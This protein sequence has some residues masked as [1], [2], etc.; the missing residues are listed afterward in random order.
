MA[1]PF[2]SYPFDAAGVDSFTRPIFIMAFRAPTTNDIQNP[3]TRW[4]NNAVNPPVISE[5]TG[6]GRW[7]D[8]T[9]GG[10]GEFTTITVDG[11]I[12][13]NGGADLN[14]GGTTINIGA[15]DSDDAI[16]IGIGGERVITLGSNQGA[17]AINILTGT[18]GFNFV[19]IEVPI[20]MDGGLAT[21]FIGTA[22]LVAGTVTIANTLLTANDR[23]FISRIAVN[24]STTLG[25]L[26][27]AITPATSFTITSATLGT[28][29]TPQAGDLSTV[30]YIIFRQ[31]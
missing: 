21:S 24:S 11:L 18:G 28:P 12:T 29:G 19:D 5:T 16:N 4:Q 25:E 31:T 20:S 27:Y 10:S 26:T 9:G 8:A 13:G 14:S 7:V 15:D 22:V 6:A 30:A 1:V 2:G 17:S 23:I 3:G